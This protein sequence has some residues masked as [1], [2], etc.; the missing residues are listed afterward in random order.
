MRRTLALNV[1]IEGE[2]AEEIGNR[3]RVCPPHNQCQSGDDYA[4]LW[5]V[6]AYNERYSSVKYH[7]QGV[8]TS[9]YESTPSAQDPMGNKISPGVPEDSGNVRE[10]QRISANILDASKECD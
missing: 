9:F 5:R 10:Y 7:S 1:L 4:R 2:G 6:K 8:Q 3:M